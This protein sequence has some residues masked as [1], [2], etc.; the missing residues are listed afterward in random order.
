[1]KVTFFVVLIL[2]ASVGKKNIGA[3]AGRISTTGGGFLEPPCG[4]ACPIGCV[5]ENYACKC[6]GVKHAPVPTSRVENNGP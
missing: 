3:E 6:P 4:L 2:L 1:M 5:C